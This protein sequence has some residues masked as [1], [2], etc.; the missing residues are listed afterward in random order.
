MAAKIEREIGPTSY[1]TRIANPINKLFYAAERFFKAI[2]KRR[3][4]P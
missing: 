2:H 3:Q 1:F 4:I